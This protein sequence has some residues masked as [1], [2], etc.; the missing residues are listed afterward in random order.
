MTNLS[1]F[2]RIRRAQVDTRNL[3]NV[4]A[5]ASQDVSLRKQR[6]NNF[7]SPTPSTCPYNGPQPGTDQCKEGQNTSDGCTSPNYYDVG[8]TSMQLLN[9]NKLQ[10]NGHVNFQY[11]PLSQYRGFGSKR[12][13]DPQW[14]P[15]SAGLHFD[16]N[17]YVWLVWKYRRAGADHL[18]FFV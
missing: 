11:I 3:R 12:N 10:A 5:E 6:R 2:E 14:Q 9:G 13:P 8:P 16:P 18:P 7:A 4:G 1:G 15:I 17:K